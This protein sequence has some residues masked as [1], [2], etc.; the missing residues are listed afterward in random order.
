MHRALL[1][2]SA[3]TVLMSRVRVNGSA[4]AIKLA[5]SNRKSDKK[6]SQIEAVPLFPISKTIVNVKFLDI[7]EYL[8]CSAL[9]KSLNSDDHDE[10]QIPNDCLKSDDSVSSLAEFAQ[11]LRITTFWGL[12]TLPLPVIDF[13]CQN[14]LCLVGNSRRRRSGT[15]DD[16]VDRAR[17]ELQQ[18]LHIHGWPDQSSNKVRQ[19]VSG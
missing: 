11:V 17:G 7:P 8:Q 18:W 10:I 2:A 3:V 6:P 1:G 14:K 5:G 12:D 19:D 9:Y 16:F 15:K 13:C 4:K